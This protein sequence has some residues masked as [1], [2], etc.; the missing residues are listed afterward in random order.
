MNRNRSSVRSLLFTFLLAIAFLIAGNAHALQ[1]DDFDGGFDEVL[2]NEG[3]S[4][5]VYLGAVG[6]ERTLQWESADGPGDSLSVKLTG[7]GG[8]GNGILVHDEGGPFGSQSKVRWTAGL[9]GSI[10]LTDGGSSDFFAIDLLNV[11]LSDRFSLTVDDGILTVTVD[12]TADAM[13]GLTIVPFSDFTDQ[14]A[15][16]NLGAIGFVDLFITRRPL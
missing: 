6:G 8:G 11:G 10:D 15:S 13:T 16:L 5:T 2:G 12:F 1:I 3:P 14:N 4:T 7:G 9:A